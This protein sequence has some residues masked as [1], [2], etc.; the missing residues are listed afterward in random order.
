MIGCPY[1]SKGRRGSHKSMVLAAATLRCDAR[2]AMIKV[3]HEVKVQR[4]I[5]FPIT[6]I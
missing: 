2:C 1:E 5:I 4:F 6:V 3:Y